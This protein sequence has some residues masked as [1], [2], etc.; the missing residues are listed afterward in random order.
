MEADASPVFVDHRKTIAYIDI[1]KCK[2]IY[3]F[4]CTYATQFIRIHRQ[5]VVRQSVFP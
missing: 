2:H 5:Y 4:M 1:R 3:V